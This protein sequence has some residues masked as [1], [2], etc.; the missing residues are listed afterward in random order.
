MLHIRLRLHGML[1]RFVA[2]ALRAPVIERRVAPGASLKHAVEAL[3]VPHTG[4]A[5]AVCN[6]KPGRMDA[7]V[8]DRDVLDLFDAASARLDTTFGA[9]HARR[10]ATPIAPRFL[11]DSHLGALAQAL[12]M[13]GFD[14]LYDNHYADAEI[15]VLARLDQR[16][17]LS[18]DRE[19]LKRRGVD[20]GAYVHAQGRD[21]Q[22]HEVVA[23]FQLAPLAQPF[24]LCLRCNV[25]LR[26]MPLAQAAP[27][28]PPRVL[29]R[30]RHFTTCDACQR[31]FWEGTHFTRMRERL[32][33]WLA[34]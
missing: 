5:M 21:A 25:R 20:R 13:A 31:V 19:L 34:A 7:A 30:C 22:M 6:G 11:A 23:R 17:V 15:V 10:A 18:R 14:T 24:R 12:R 28:V 4:I 33:H 9:A 1:L 26:P 32:S 29:E 3:G 27:R 2:P 16:T 8:S